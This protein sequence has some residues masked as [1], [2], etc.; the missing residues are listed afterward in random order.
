MRALHYCGLNVGGERC[1]R[2]SRNLCYRSTV[3]DT[4]RNFRIRSI[5]WLS[6]AHYLVANDFRPKGKYNDTPSRI[7]N[8]GDIWKT[9]MAIDAMNVRKK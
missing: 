8:V 2:L 1:D 3:P 5:P 6:R 7:N 4:R 9:R